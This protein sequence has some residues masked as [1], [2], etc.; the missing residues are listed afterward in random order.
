MEPPLSANSPHP[1]TMAML[2]QKLCKLADSVWSCMPSFVGFPL[3]HVYKIKEVE[4]K[5]LNFSHRMPKVRQRVYSCLEEPAQLNEI[6]AWLLE[7]AHA[8]RGNS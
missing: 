8:A 5:T 1:P 7:S 4:G 2:P 3:M 6:K